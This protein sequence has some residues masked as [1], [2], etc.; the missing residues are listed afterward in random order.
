MTADSEETKIA[1]KTEEN[2]FIFIF[3]NKYF[4]LN[5]LPHPTEFVSDVQKVKFHQKHFGWR[6]NT[7]VSAAT[8][9]A[10]TKKTT[11]LQFFFCAVKTSTE[12]TKS[13]KKK[14]VKKNL[15]FYKHLINLKMEKILVQADN[16]KKV[17]LYEIHLPF[18]LYRCNT[19]THT[20]NS[21]NI[22]W[23]S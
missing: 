23:F 11:E 6:F 20:Q 19:H 13:K 10:T 22:A 17:K 7:A 8:A 9:A 3:Y 18:S 14:N 4:P 5:T 16:N 21:Q 12:I 2:R 1:A 15:Y